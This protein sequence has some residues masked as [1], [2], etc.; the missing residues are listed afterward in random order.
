[1][2][3]LTLFVSMKKEGIIKQYCRCN[4][5]QNKCQE[6]RHER[7]GRAEALLC[8]PLVRSALRRD[9]QLHTRYIHLFLRNLNQCLSIARL[10]NRILN[11]KWVLTF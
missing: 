8:R 3:P 10:I 2:L 1:M 5:R 7:R 11:E 6:G 9:A 4:V